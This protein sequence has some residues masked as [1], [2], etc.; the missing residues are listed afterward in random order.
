MSMRLL[1]VGL[2]VASAAAA[3]PSRDGKLVPATP[4]SL[5]RAA[6]TET[7][8]L[9]GTVLVAG[10]CTNAGCELGSPGSDTAEVYSPKTGDFARVGRLRGGSRDD[11]VAVLLGDGRVLLAGGW[12]A[13]S[14]GP[15]DTTELYDP[16]TRSF[17][18]GPRLA[19]G[20]GGIAAVRLRDGR[21]LLTGGFTGNKPTTSIAE[22]F[23]PLTNSIAPAGRMTVARGGHSATL[24]RDG[25]VLVAGGMRNGRVVAS[26]E[27]YDPATGRFT[28]TGRM[29]VA[30]YKT[31]AITLRDGTALVVGGAADVDGTVLFAST[32]LYD[33]KSRRFTTGPRMH[34]PRYKLT[35]STVP[36]PNGDVLVTGGALQAE[37]FDSRAKTF[38]L[39]PGALDHTRLFLTAAALPGGRALLVGG[40]DKAIRPT[41]ATWL[42]R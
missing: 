23:D 26:A 14:A 22:L 1:L 17:S 8:L 21:V 25:R 36:L 16:S 34:L 3:S 35:G 11:H 5:P 4:M 40:Y 31:A 13:S 7:A 28:P 37:R 19:V 6:H 27:L 39:V 41:A 18:A 12:G 32:E 20:R 15:L 2:I 29:R 24:L 30:R 10:G 38:R 9:D 42:Y 33:P